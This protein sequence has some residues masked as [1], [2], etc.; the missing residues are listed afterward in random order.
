M[1]LML[2]AA[3]SVFFYIN[4]VLITILVLMIGTQL[5]W[6]VRSKISG[7]VIDGE[8]FAKGIHRGQVVDLRDENKFKKDHMLGA[9]N[10]PFMQFKMYK[11][12]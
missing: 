11:D 7:N 6:F 10:M 12:A 3:H 5:Y 9:R 8:E 2:G 1:N 4:I